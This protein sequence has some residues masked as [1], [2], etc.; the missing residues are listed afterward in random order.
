MSDNW[1]Q[2]NWVKAELYINKLQLRIVKAT[3]NEKWGLVKRLQY[4]I[5]HS[6]YARA[7]DV[8]R[9]VSNKGKNTSGIDMVI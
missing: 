6:Y 2:I 1:N 5:T 7:L 3:Q 8:K 4:L 9:V